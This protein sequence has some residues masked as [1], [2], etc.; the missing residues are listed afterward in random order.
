MN[1]IETKINSQKARRTN[2]TRRG[3]TRG[4]TDRVDRNSMG[5]Q[6][7]SIQAD[8]G[9]VGDLQSEDNQGCQHCSLHQPKGAIATTERKANRREEGMEIQS[10]LLEPGSFNVPPINPLL[11]EGNS[12][13]CQVILKDQLT[14]KSKSYTRFSSL[15]LKKTRK[16]GQG[17]LQK[18]ARW[19]PRILA[20]P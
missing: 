10:T 3:A 11:R 15:I 20:L 19:S 14:L 16:Q 18:H 2:N 17:H 8:K 6:S 1:S 5:V 13:H 12:K 7:P 9:N 4:H